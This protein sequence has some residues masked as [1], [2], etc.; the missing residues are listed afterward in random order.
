MGLNRRISVILFS[1]NFFPRLQIFSH[2]YDYLR[3]P[4]ARVQ[5][6]EPAGPELAGGKGGRP[7]Q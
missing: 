2:T 1:H 5:A 6:A 4:A 3:K 7:Q